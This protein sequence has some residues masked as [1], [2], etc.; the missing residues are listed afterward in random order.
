MIKD[1]IYFKPLDLVFTAGYL[2]MDNFK[3]TI[4]ESS[5][6][7]LDQNGASF[8]IHVTTMEEHIPQWVDLMSVACEFIVEEN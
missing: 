7:A 6:L 3:S 5:V 2:S 4:N 8:A 1:N